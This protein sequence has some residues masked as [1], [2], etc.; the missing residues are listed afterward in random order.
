MTNFRQLLEENNLKEKYQIL[1]LYCNWTLHTNI[2]QSISAY[3]MLERISDALI[4]YGVGEYEEGRV[5]DIVIETIALHEL[6][7]EIMDL[8]KKYQIEASVKFQNIDTCY[9]FTGELLLILLEK[10]LIIDYNS[11]KRN[12]K[13]EKIGVRIYKKCLDQKASPDYYLVLGFAFVISDNKINW[14]L[15]TKYTVNNNIS[16]V[17]KVVLVDRKELDRVRAIWL[18]DKNS[19]NK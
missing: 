7:E 12:K 3:R 6:F 14:R 8:S 5:S 13:L 18:Q 4:Q 19:K 16:L 11:I 15:I 10:P 17:G 1:N 2:T 9:L